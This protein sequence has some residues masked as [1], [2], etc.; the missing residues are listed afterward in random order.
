MAK[1][2]R[3]SEG[4]YRCDGTVSIGRDF[5]SLFERR[6]AP[7]LDTMGVQTRPLIHLLKEAYRQGIVDAVSVMHKLEG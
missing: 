1:M 2:G 4:A 3:P 6:V 5:D 7:F